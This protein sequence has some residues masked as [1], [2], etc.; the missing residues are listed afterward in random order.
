MNSFLLEMVG[1]QRYEEMMRA[2]EEQRRV[3]GPPAWEPVGGLLIRFG[4]SLQ[5]AGERLT[6]GALD[7]HAVGGAR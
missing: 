4:R 6:G 1:R 2:A 3:P 5:R 7:G